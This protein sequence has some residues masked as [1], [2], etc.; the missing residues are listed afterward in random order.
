MPMVMWLRIASIV[1]WLQGAAHAWLFVTASPKHGPEEIAV[2]SAMRSHQFNFLGSMRSYWDFYYGSGLM[3]AATVFVNAAL[4][5]MLASLAATQPQA[6]RPIVGLFVVANL[7]HAALAWRY[8]F[9]TPIVPDLVIAG[10][11]V[12]A[13]LA[14]ASVPVR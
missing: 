14:T 12:A 2:V 9:V 8:F 5:W 6:I 3:V 7:V 13:L 11:L 4:Y 1:A 10:C